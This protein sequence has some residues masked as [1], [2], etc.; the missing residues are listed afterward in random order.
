MC[1]N[2]DIEMMWQVGFCLGIENYFCYI[3]GRGFGM[4]FVILFDYFFE[5]FLF[6]IDELYVIVLQIGGMYEGDIFCKCN[7]VEY[8]FWLL[9]VCDNC[10]LIWEEFVD[11]I[12]QMVYLFVILGFY[13]FSQ[14]GGEFV[15]Q[16]IW[17]IGLV[18]LKVVVKLIK[19]QIDD[20]IGEICIWVDVD[21]W[22]LV[23]MLI[24]K[25]VEDFIDYLLE[26]GIW[27]C[28]LYLEV[29]ML[30][31]VELLC[32]LCL[33]DYDVLVGINLFCE[34]LDLFEVLLVVIFD[35]D[36]EGFLWLSCSLIQIIGCVVCNVFGEVYMYV[37]K[38]IDL[39]REVIDEIECWW[40]KQIVYNEVNGIDLQ[41]LCKKIVDIFDQ[42]YWEVDDIVV[43]EV[44]GFG[45]NV[46]CGWWVQGEFGW[47][48]SV[49]VFEGCDI[50]VMLCVELVD[51]IKDFI[52]QMMVVVCDLQ[53][54]LVVWFCDEIVDFKWELWGMDVVGLK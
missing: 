8:G 34:G 12:G 37:D 54:E 47:V 44:G 32:Q 43:V 1:I 53:F 41:L 13:E 49:G 4:L 38:I 25:M 26:M 20:L 28:Y 17:L 36:K 7:L 52:V 46:F 16:V 33:G 30:C 11:W 40:V 24:K 19:G 42:V 27:V 45:C 22:V 35:V 9:L 21:Q 51:L 6:V 3:D 29:D 50:F 31:W 5:D 2:Y 15:E 39:M 14:I 18:D 10:L 23:M 48:V